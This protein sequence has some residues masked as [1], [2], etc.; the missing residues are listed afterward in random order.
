KMSRPFRIFALPL[1]RLPRPNLPLP[2][3]K[4]TPPTKP[5]DSSTS[6]TPKTENPEQNIVN[7]DSNET[8]TSTVNQDTDQTSPLLLFHVSQPDPSPESSPPSLTSRALQ[9]A[10]DAWLKLGEKPKDSWMGWFYSRGEGLMDKIE[11]EEWALKGVHEGRGVKLVKDGEI[12]ERIEIPLLYPNLKDPMPP[13]I[14][15]LDKM[16]VHRVPYHRKMMIR[17][18]VFS[19][20][21]FPFALIPIIP[22]FPLFY[23]LWRAWSHYKAWRGATYLEGLLRLG[24]IKEVPS[25]ILTDVYQESNH[26]D[27][28]GPTKVSESN[29]LTGVGDKKEKEKEKEKEE[30]ANNTS[31][32]PSVLLSTEKIS[33]LAETFHLRP[34]EIMD[35]TRA[36]EQADL[37]AKAIDKEN[38]SI[39]N[40]GS[41]W[42][43]NLHR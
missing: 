40:D 41:G 8:K 6:I 42:R 25:T 39:E 27:H 24:M 5:L 12:Q 33:R 29:G 20:V 19:P 15:K 10:S 18:L 17:S 14:P 11:Y 36:V 13:L 7:N 22:N 3:P 16:L 34:Q 1:S 26:M 9:R 43:G 37:R 2:L 31:R 21:T 4:N 23:V 38:T 32:H 28:S 30:K 35:I